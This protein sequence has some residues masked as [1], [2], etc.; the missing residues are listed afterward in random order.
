MAGDQAESAAP[1]REV[2]G[3][4]RHFQERAH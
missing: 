3:Q 4:S 1:H 2:L